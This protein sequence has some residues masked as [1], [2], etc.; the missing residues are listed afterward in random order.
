MMEI[1]SCYNCAHDYGFYPGC[2][3]CYNGEYYAPHPTIE[4]KLYELTVAPPPLK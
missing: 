4:R 1:N 2:S 3:E